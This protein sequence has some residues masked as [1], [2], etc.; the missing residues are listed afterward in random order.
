VL[1]LQ[2][3]ATLLLLVICTF[4]PGFFVVRRLRWS[5]GWSAM[6]KLC[7]SIALSLIFLWLA[8][9]TLYLSGAPPAAYY[10]VSAISLALGIASFSD[11]RK[12]LAIG[13]LRHA[14]MGFAFLVAWTLVALAIIRVYNGARWG[15]D[16]LE[17]FQRSLFFLHHFPLDAE[18]FG[19]YKLPARPP[20]EN[21][22]AAF[23]LGQV[24]DR[25]ELF[26]IV[27]AFLN[28]LLFL[29]CCLAL[30][31][32][33]RSRRFG[34]LPLVTVFATSPIVMQNATYTWTKLLTAFFVILAIVFYL[35]GWRRRDTARMVFA[36]LCLAMGLLAHYSAGPYIVFFALHYLI[37]V[38]PKR[39]AKWKELAII[40]ASCG[41]LIATWFGWSI[42]TYGVNATFASNTSIT[43]SQAYQ[44]GTLGKIAGNIIDTFVP[45]FLRGEALAHFFDQPN[46]TALL[47][48]HIF[49]VYQVQLLLTMGI[50]GGVLVVWL[51][52]KAFRRRWR[53]PSERT[54]WIS[55]IAVTVFIGLV[56]VGER[57]LFGS[58]H[59]TLLPMEVLGLTLLAAKFRRSRAI[60]LLIFAGCV[61]DFSLGVFLH[62]RVQHLENTPGD[63]LYTGPLVVN[64]QVLLPQMQDSLS[65]AAREN[66]S[67]KHQLAN[68]LQWKRELENADASGKAEV[69]AMMDRMISDDTRLFHGWYARHGGEV[70]Y[71]G[72]HFG[73]SDIPSALLL[74]LCAG[75]LWKTSQQIPGVSPIRPAPKSKSARPKPK[76]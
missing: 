38:F 39:T 62:L 67:R 56:V 33:A 26:Q 73:A 66:W 2:A 11:L 31:M 53:H 22:L 57:D 65:D 10:A 19:N 69:I 25:F 55:L 64:R 35:K 47:R 50:I 76:R 49:I 30:P 1:L 5:A 41:A 59:L 12:L 44:G 18:I 34:V 68:A 24:G 3:V 14:V 72:D 48:D 28:L 23:F 54:F 75:L 9:W 70:E 4:A 40:A 7:A 37:A 63:A 52:V 27:F 20:A 74:I 71:L 6:E 21:V 13:R 51:L 15:G 36:F 43:A 42:A 45:H 16:W 17:H 46:R 32:L 8:A 58:A 29:P 60:A 61:I